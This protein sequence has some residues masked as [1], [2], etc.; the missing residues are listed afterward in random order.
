MAAPLHIAPVHN[1][2]VHITASRELRLVTMTVS[3]IVRLAATTVRDAIPVSVSDGNQVEQMPQ[4]TR[5]RDVHSCVNPSQ[6]LRDEWLGFVGHL[7]DY[8]ATI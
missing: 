6:Q 3:R 2:Q 4:P 1:E 7:A 8:A 5:H